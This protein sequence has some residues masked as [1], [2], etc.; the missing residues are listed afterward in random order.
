[1]FLD[2]I[3]S[4]SYLNKD[5]QCSFLFLT[6]LIEQSNETIKNLFKIQVIKFYLKSNLL[7]Y[8]KL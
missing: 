4:D 1:M 5:Q 2:S 3:E 8:S 6:H 7:Y